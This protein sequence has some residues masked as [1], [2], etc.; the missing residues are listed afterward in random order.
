MR[1]TILPAVLVAIGFTGAAAAQPDPKPA[2][3]PEPLVTRTYSLKA[4]LG[5][6]PASGNKTTPDDVIKMIFETIPVGEIKPGVEGPQLIERDGGQLEVRATEKVQGEIKDLITALERLADLAIDIKVD[7]YEFDRATFEKS[8]LPLFAP[9][10]GRKESRVVVGYGEDDEPAPQA[11]DA[12]KALKLGTV[13]QSSAR[14]YANGAEAVVSSRQ[15]VVPYPRAP[16]ELIGKALG[17]VP[18]V[19]EGFRLVATP[20]VSADRRFIRFKLTEQSAA[21]VGMKKRDFGE[22]GGQPFVLVSPVVEDIG[23]TGTVEVADGAFALFRLDYA[24]KDKAWMV[25]LRPRLYI[26]AEEEELKKQKK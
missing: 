25:V 2:A 5:L 13:V 15:T 8:V 11:A 6:K 17:P 16:N 7:L 24:P 21:L 9:P 4:V 10:K 19:K 20:V 18:Y 23:K 26:K 1:A 14:R 12:T 22:I 3:K